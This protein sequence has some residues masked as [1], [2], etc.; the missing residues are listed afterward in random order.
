[1]KIFGKRKRKNIDIEDI[2]SDARNVSGMNEQ[3]FEGVIEQPLDNTNFLW[4]TGVLVVVCSIFLIRLSYIQ[5]VQHDHYETIAEENRLHKE[6]LFAARGVI[7]DRFGELLA[8]NTS[9]PTVPYLRRQYKKMPGLSHLVGFIRYPAADKKGVFW[10]LDTEGVG[11][12]EEILNTELRGRTGYRLTEERGQTKADADM[13]VRPVDGANITV[14]IDARMQQALGNSLNTFMN[15]FDFQAAAAVVMDV[16]TGDIVS[17]VSLPD[18][19]ANKVTS[20]DSVYL[21][22]LLQDSSNPFLNRVT[23]GLFTPGSIVKPFVAY[24]ALA[25][26]LVTKDT[27]VFSSG[28]IE[29]PNPYNPDKPSIFRDW[30]PEGH[31]VTNVEFAIADSVNTFFYSVGGGYHGQKGM[32]I[33]GIEKSV[34][35]FGLGQEVPFI[36]PAG[37]KGTV[38]NPAWKQKTFGEAWRLG[39]T[40]ISAI[41]QFG[42]QVTP[43]QMV[44]ATAAM[45]NRGVLVEPRLLPSDE[46]AERQLKLDQSAVQIVHEGMRMTVT[47]GTAKMLQVPYMNIA[48]KTGSA[49]VGVRKDRMNS[50]I[51]GFYPYED[52]QYAFALLAERGPKTGAP[53]VGWSLRYALDELHTTVDTQK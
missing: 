43:L 44:R 51:I 1:M 15:Q 53:N 2:L 13:V 31:G 34:K 5:I 6:P 32:G 41:G 24:E 27:T 30:R 17:L 23:K 48:A 40:Y 45:A 50:W 11:G 14:T 18:F 10:R 46:I 26:G 16:H 36:L 19:D 35:R 20:G 37:T 29:V 4:A 22:S 3:Q 42:F 39:D 7:T 47:D 9:D 33:S 21:G 28:K 38:P 12:L 49:Q 52:P 8:W 25:E